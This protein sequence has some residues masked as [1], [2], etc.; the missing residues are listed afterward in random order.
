MNRVW[1][2]AVETMSTDRG[3]W[4]V[5]FTILIGLVAFIGNGS[6]ALWDQDE[7]AYAGFAREMV[8]SG[9]W[10]VP[11]F[12][13]SEAHRKPPLLLWGI[14]SGFKLLGESE[15]LVRLPALLGTC[16]SFLAVL[17]FGRPLVGAR[18]A[19]LAS[20]GLTLEDVRGAVAGA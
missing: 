1:R 9:D 3:R 8:R 17:W 15:F 7:A 2:A 10:V 16:G 11:H 12:L 14:A 6:T 4:I 20:M 5:I 19:R 13:W 18:A